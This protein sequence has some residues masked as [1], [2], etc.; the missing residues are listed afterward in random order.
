MLAFKGG[1]SGV[2][3]PNLERLGPSAMGLR[4]AMRHR[5]IHVGQTK[6]IT[7]LGDGQDRG[8][9]GTRVPL[10]PRAGRHRAAQ[11]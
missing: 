1:T 7:G 2:D 4:D 10:S 6:N 5:R 9:A 8:S 3:E 11:R